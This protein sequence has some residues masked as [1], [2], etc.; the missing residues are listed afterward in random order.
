MS[1]GGFKKQINKASQYMSEKVLKE[2]G[3]EIEEEFRELEK[4]V[5]ATNDVSMKL[6]EKVK[7]LLYPNPA[8]RGK[9]SAKAAYGKI[10]GKQQELR[11][12][13][14]EAQ[15]S[16]I[17]T[18]ASVDLGDDSAFGTALRDTADTL[19]TVAD[20]REMLEIN[21]QQNFMDPLTMLINKDI[22]E[23]LHHRKKM[24][25]RR[26]DF[27]AKKRKQAKGSNV[28]DVE[29]NLAEEKFEESKELAETGM[30]NLLEGDV[31]QIGQISALIE[32]MSEMHRESASLLQNLHAEL[33]TQMDQASSKPREFRAP[34]QRASRFTSTRRREVDSD[35]D[36]PPP[37][38]SPTK[39]S[40]S[41][42]S[43]AN[44]PHALALYDFDPENEGEMGFREGDTIYLTERIDE[45]WMA[46]ECNGEAG[47]F[48]ANY[49]DVI[50]DV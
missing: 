5:D 39:T 25:G 29:I 22:K 12:P 21:V 17:M 35:E 37:K 10:A 6:L 1:V 42:N 14:V 38:P 44:R 41:S 26:L 34:K 20:Q 19:K 47:F 27:D 4:K 36:E 9:I 33:M 3:T 7:E 45:N 15:M 2:K 24:E 32:A 43:S 40:R 13:H 11:Y 30:M 50:V 18:K 31:E 8:A 28:T 23:I 46:G 48:P 16:D 49:V